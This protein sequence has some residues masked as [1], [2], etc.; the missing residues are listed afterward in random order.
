[1]NKKVLDL[2]SENAM[3]VAVIIGII[4]LASGNDEM[5]YSLRLHILFLSVL[6][7]AMI[8][9]KVYDHYTYINK[10][11]AIN[12]HKSVIQEQLKKI[13]EDKKQQE[14]VLLVASL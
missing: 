4:A 14:L 8:I 5:L 13:E 2:A 11:S 10:N 7:T 1:M 9:V 3:S 12:I 6:I